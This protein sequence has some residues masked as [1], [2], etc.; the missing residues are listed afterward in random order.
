MDLNKHIF[1]SDNK[2]PLHSNGYAEIANGSH[3]GATS[4]T[5][6]EQRKLIDHNRQSVASYRNSTIGNESGQVRSYSGMGNIN[7]SSRNIS[8][9]QLQQLKQSG[10]L[11]RSQFQQ[12]QQTQQRGSNFIVPTRQFQEPNS[13][14]YNPYK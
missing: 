13:R 11:S 1:H 2:K 12:L 4:N 10:I 6:Y 3:F 5:T 14:S 8:R 7:R 9:S